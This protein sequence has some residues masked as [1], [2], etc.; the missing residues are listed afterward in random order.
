M[1]YYNEAK[2]FSAW[3]SELKDIKVGDMQLLFDNESVFYR[4]L[5]SKGTTEEKKEEIK[6]I[7][8]QYGDAGSAIFNVSASNNPEDEGSIFNMHKREVIRQ[9]LI[10]NLN[11]AITS[12]SRNSPGD[13]Q[14]PILTETDWDHI[15]RNVSIIT[16]VQNMPIGMKYYNNYAVAT[17]TSNK[18]YVNP[19]GIYLSGDGDE[20]YHMPYCDKL[21]GNKIIGYRNTDYA[22]RSYEV[23]D[24]IKYYYRHENLANQEC[25][26]C[27]VQRSLYNEDKTLEKEIAYKTALARE[28]YVSHEFR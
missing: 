25:Y 15:F 3:V 13:Y 28:R 20:Y 9:S 6:K 11:Q 16:F 26:Y 21:F 1:N 7:K 12:Y 5:D 14:L 8:N 23:N 10:S 19:D 27:L 4:D 18:E 2:V 22:L 17:S 24:K